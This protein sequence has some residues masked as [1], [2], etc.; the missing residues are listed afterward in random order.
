LQ[1]VYDEYC[2]ATIRY[3]DKKVSKLNE[4]QAKLDKHR[5]EIQEILAKAKAEES[6]LQGNVDAAK[7]DL[8]TFGKENLYGVRKVSTCGFASHE[9]QQGYG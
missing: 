6:R 7:N 3:K 2:D 8:V 5:E 9:S 1:T 4:E